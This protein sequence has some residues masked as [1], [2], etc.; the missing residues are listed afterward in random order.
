M[1]VYWSAKAKA[2]L[3]EI[4]DY[5]AKN[6]PLRAQQVVDRLTRRSEKLAFPP[7]ADRSVPE[8]AQDNLREVLERPFRI[9]F[10]VSPDRIDIITVKH[11]RQRLP[12]KPADL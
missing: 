2:R 10:L 4:H 1:I 6:S 3:R 11:Y 5:I 12:E 8:F 7:R 9:I